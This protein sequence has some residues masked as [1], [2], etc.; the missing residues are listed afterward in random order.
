MIVR[1]MVSESDD[2]KRI[3][4]TIRKPDQRHS[5]MLN[6]RALKYGTRQRTQC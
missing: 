5:S 3:R 4:N 2:F 6:C 1:K